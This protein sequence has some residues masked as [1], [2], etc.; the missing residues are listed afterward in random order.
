MGL[1]AVLALSALLLTIF[2]LFFVTSMPG[3]SYQGPFQTLTKTENTVS[4]RLKQHVR[5][6]AGEI[7]ERNIRRPGSME[8]AAAYIRKMLLQSGYEVRS[9]KFTAL[10]KRVANLEATIPGNIRPEE[11]VLVGAHY[12]TVADSP[13]ADDNGSG[14]AGALELGRLLAAGHFARTVRLVFFANEEAPFYFLGQMGSQHYARE[15]RARGERIV[16]MFSLETLGYYSDA[17][18]S[19]RY[20]FPFSFFYPDRGNFIAFVG[21]LRS[22]TLVRKSIGLFRESTPFPSEGTA[23]PGWLNGIGWSD[24]RSFW[25]QGYQALMLTDTALFRYPWYHSPLDRP[26]R[27]D[28]DRLARIIVGVGRVVAGL[29]NE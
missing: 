1:I 28:Y 5:A 17:P 26:D 7:G 21:N 9:Q 15:A 20:P 19:Q 29:A 27:I 22:R 6:L 3:S 25:Q 24:H 12:D 11:I 10:G 4:G 14:V 13:G 23:A 2:M 18:Y 16:A 8:A